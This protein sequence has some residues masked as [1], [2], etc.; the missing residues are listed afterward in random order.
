MPKFRKKPVVVEAVQWLLGVK[1]PGVAFDT[2]MDR[3]YVITIHEQRA[4]LDPGD[5]IIPENKPG[6]FYPIKPDTLKATYEAVV[7][8][9]R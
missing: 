4:Y 2:L 6:R 9:E 5:W 3:Y 8:G 7:E 1:H